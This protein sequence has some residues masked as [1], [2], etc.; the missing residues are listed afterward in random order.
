MVKRLPAIWETRVRS[1]GREDPLEKEMTTHSTTLAWKIPWTKEPGRLEP[2][3]SQ[4]VRHDWAT[5][6]LMICWFTQPMLTSWLGITIYSFTSSVHTLP[7]SGLPPAWSLTTFVQT[8][9]DSIPLH[10]QQLS[11]VFLKHRWLHL[12]PTIVS[13]LQFSKPVPSFPSFHVHDFP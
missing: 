4:R 9:F 2:M 5:S 10:C 3:R 12:T 7:S 6:L 13:T 11:S 1:L 8:L